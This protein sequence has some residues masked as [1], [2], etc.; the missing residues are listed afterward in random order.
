MT[1]V[2]H[3]LS[4]QELPAAFPVSAGRTA[5]T[6][7]IGRAFVCRAIASMVGNAAGMLLPEKGIL[8][9]SEFVFI[10]RPQ[11]TALFLDRYWLWSIYAISVQTIR[12][13]P[14]VQLTVMDIMNIRAA[15]RSA[16]TVHTW[17]SVP[18]AG[19]M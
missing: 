15:E 4:G 7:R 5:K 1:V 10:C 3:T 16:K 12:Y 8:K 17:R 14:T 11:R 6:W 9:L 18:K 2:T 19:I 13:C